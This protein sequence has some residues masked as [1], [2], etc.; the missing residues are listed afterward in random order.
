MFVKFQPEDSPP[1]AFIKTFNSWSDYIGSQ[2]AKE[3]DPNALHK[4][5]LRRYNFPNADGF[6]RLLIRGI[7]NGAFDA[8]ALM[9]FAVNMEKGLSAQDQ[10]QASV[11]SWNDFHDYFD[12]N[13]DLDV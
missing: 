5:T 11:E 6:D 8:D 9:I 1:I 13:Q 3:V 10:Q 2:R 4:A 12:D 7:E